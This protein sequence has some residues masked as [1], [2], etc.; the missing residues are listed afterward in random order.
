MDLHRPNAIKG[1][2]NGSRVMPTITNT[3]PDSIGCTSTPS[4]A[5]NVFV[6]VS[7]VRIDSHASRTA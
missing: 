6:C 4:T 3:L 7:P 1:P 2:N 5:S